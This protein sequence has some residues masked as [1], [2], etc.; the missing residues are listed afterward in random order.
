MGHDH[1]AIIGSNLPPIV[2]AGLR[3]CRMI[4]V[5]WLPRP[6]PLLLIPSGIKTI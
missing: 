6:A 3:L 4:P 2:A 5:V 1:D